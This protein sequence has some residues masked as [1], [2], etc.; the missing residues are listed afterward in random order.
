MGDAAGARSPRALPARRPSVVHQEANS[1]AGDLHTTEPTKKDAREVRLPAP[2]D[3]HTFAQPSQPL[4]CHNHDHHLS[5]I[6]FLMSVE[7]LLACT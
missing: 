7:H 6:G 2:A 4:H 1:L 5:S 3:I